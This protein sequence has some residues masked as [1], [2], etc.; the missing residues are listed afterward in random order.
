[1][2]VNAHK[3]KNAK[4]ADGFGSGLGGDD[5]DSQERK[6][7]QQQS[8]AKA[9]TE[10]KADV[11]QTKQHKGGDKFFA[12]VFYNKPQTEQDDFAES[13]ERGDPDF[14]SRIKEE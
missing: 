2:R 9:G 5:E 12:I 1:M 13:P 4:N 7:R 14:N 3:L 10:K 6:R 8:A 11:S